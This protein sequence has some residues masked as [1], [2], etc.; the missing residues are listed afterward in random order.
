MS[1]EHLAVL[2]ECHVRL[3]S[4]L[5]VSHPMDVLYQAKIFSEDDMQRVDRETTDMDKRRKF[6]SILKRKKDQAHGKFVGSLLESQT[7]LAVD[8]Q[9]SLER[10]KEDTQKNKNGRPTVRQTD[11]H[12]FS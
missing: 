11:N 5:D 7:H 1:D 4:D 9:T 2:R 8:L 12:N 10:I 3:C 6:L